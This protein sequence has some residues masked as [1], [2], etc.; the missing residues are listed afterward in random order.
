[1]SLMVGVDVGGTK[2]AAGVV[3]ADGH[4]IEKLKRCTPAASTELTAKVVADAVTELR[5]R[6]DVGG[7]GIGA[8]GFVDGYRSNVLF[9]PHLAW[10]HE[11]L[12]KEVEDLVGL[13][14]VMENDANAAAWAETVLGAARGHEHVILIAVGTG[15]GAG[16][17]INGELYRGRWG[18]AGEPGHYRVV[19]G[20][21]L[22]QCGNRGCWEQY[23]SGNALVAQ[24][25]EVAKR[26][27]GAAGRLLE[28]AGGSAE[29]ING[30]EVTRAAKDGD[31][32]ALRCFETVGSWLGQGLAALA[33][34][35]DP[36]CF[37][38]GGGVSDAGELLIAPARAVFQDELT[39]GSYR[40]RAEIRLAQLG[41]DAGMIG[42]ADLARRSLPGSAPGCVQR[43]APLSGPSPRDGR[44]PSRRTITANPPT[45][46]ATASRAAQLGAF[47]P[48]SVDT[49]R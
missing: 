21:R 11:P 23:A 18:I 25:R 36:G 24:A 17:V 39:G 34:I 33:A 13:P 19:P 26:S 2:V 32:G 22:C 48:M 49:K 20:G 9:A 44:S 10:R 3:D 5:G 45:N 35:L 30:P 29:G 42:A 38:I 12:K 4:I 8:A 15:I 6:H 41:A 31:P 28:L 1:M 40:P 27:P 43:T 7:V 14:V 37:V 47:Q 46:A 16:I